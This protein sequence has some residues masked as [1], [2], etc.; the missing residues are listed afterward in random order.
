MNDENLKPLNT[1]P[2][3]EQR[4]IRQKGTQRS[5]EAKRRKKAIKQRL[6]FLLEMK[7]DASMMPTD[8]KAMSGMMGLD[9]DNI[10][11]N[12]NLLLVALF[13]Q[14]MNDIRS[15]KYID[16]LM[17]R[18]PETKLKE[19][20]VKLKEKISDVAGQANTGM[21]NALVEAVKQLGAEENDSTESTAT[22]EASDVHPG[23][24]AGD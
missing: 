22:D 11:S 8:L 20:E 10:D 9:P 7:P 12:D 19:R 18:N 3:E 14:A 4:K 15:L 21:M 17:G 24:E 1:L 2:L 13:A 5:N 6:G 23:T 16:T